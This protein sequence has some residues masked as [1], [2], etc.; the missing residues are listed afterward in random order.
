MSGHSK[1]TQIK[2]QKAV[3]D[4]RRSGVFTK[5][6]NA[7]TIA[8][9]EGGADPAMNFRLRLVIEKGKEANMPNEN[10]ER[11]IKRGSGELDGASIDEVIYEG[12][13]PQGVAVIIEAAT[14]SK[15]R[16]TSDIRN[17]LNKYQGHLG[18]SGSVKWMFEQK[19]AIRIIKNLVSN[20]E[21][22]ELQMI[23][24]GAE[25]I[26][27]EEEGFTIVTKVG[28]LG[29]IRD[30]LIKMNI[31]PASSEIEFLPKTKVA[32]TGEEAK[33]KLNKIFEELEE[34]D[35]VNNYFTNA[36]H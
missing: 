36:N 16:T 12:F 26:Q 13:G 3:T 2:R 19:G 25:D 17:I 1:W 11:A 31:K 32:I 23:D 9:K 18:N 24:A 27:E 8:A 6:A 33:G 20:K 22:F 35:E 29:K 4:K 10:I 30:L 28:D 14:D 34:L 15:N 5:L 7:I 21:E